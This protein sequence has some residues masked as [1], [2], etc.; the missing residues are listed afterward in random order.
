MS[1]SRLRYED[2]GAGGFPQQA[3]A[4][5]ASYSMLEADINDGWAPTTS[6][7]TRSRSNNHANTTNG[8]VSAKETMVVLDGSKMYD[9][10]GG[11][12]GGAMDLSSFADAEC[13]EADEGANV[14]VAF[15]CSALPGAPARHRVPLSPC[16]DLRA[17]LTLVGGVSSW[18]PR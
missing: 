18:R 12:G 8:G 9:D 6:A 3:A 13:A 4:P 5:D 2:V 15:A 17:R 11:G 1:R 14:L 7:S 16:A 10:M